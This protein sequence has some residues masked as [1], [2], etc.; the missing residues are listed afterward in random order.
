MATLPVVKQLQVLKQRTEK[1]L[2]RINTALIALNG[3]K[4]R[5]GRVLSKEARER[6]ADAQR[7]RWA[8][9][10]KAAKAQAKAA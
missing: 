2:D 1:D 8:K 6:I 4:K 5:P 9:V 3:G 10:R 7:L